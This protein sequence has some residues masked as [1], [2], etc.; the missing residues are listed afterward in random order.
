MAAREGGW[1]QWACEFGDPDK[2][3]PRPSP[4]WS[5]EAELS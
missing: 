4:C 1:L 5:G 2:P 3:R